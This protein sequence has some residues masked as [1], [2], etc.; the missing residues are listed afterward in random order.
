MTHPPRKRAWQ[1]LAKTNTMPFRFLLST[2][3]GSFVCAHRI[4]NEPMS[5]LKRTMAGAVSSLQCACCV[6]SYGRVSGS[7]LQKGLT[8]SCTSGARNGSV[9]PEG[10]FVYAAESTRTNIVWTMFTTLLY[11]DDTGAAILPGHRPT[12]VSAIRACFI[13]SATYVVVVISTDAVDDRDAAMPC[14][15]PCFL[16]PNARLH[17]TFERICMMSILLTCIPINQYSSVT[18]IHTH[19]SWYTCR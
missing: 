16:A 4:V 15:V 12:A 8:G 18:N 17:C 11:L 14:H 3:A 2:K 1:P 13:R 5:L 9:L 6:H 10:I 7:H 19:S